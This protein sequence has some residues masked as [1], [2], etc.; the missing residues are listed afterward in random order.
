MRHR[1]ADKVYRLILRVYPR[2]FRER[3]GTDMASAYHAARLDAR[4][5][6]RAGGMEFW[7]GVITDGLVRA[8]VEHL[9]MTMSDLRYAAR[10]LMRTPV[11]T[12]VAIL[13]I[14]LGIGANAAI[15]SAVRAV[16]LRPLGLT[17]AERLVRIWEKNDR[18]KIRRFAVSVPNYVDWRAQSTV[19]EELGAWRSGSTT[20]TTGGEPQRLDSL[21][22]TATVLPLLGVQPMIGRNFL[23][24]E[25][26][27]GGAHVALLFESVWRER[28]GANPN[29]VGQSITP[30]RCA[31]RRHRHRAGRQF[32]IRAPR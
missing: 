10:G 30:R 13:T 24:E 16:A 6:G 8:P 17:D 1:L 23:P 11:F 21:Q 31:V 25:D 28:F 19:F 18:L 5:R 20:L 27:P 32:S 2:E 3:F 26:R 7:F 9:H 29:L 14:A 4:Q 15:F 12:I 22:A